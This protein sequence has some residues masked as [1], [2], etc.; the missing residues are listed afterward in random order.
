MHW[1]AD[2]GGEQGQHGVGDVQG[3]DAGEK[4]D[5]ERQQRFDG[6]ALNSPS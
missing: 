3:E 6:T 4:D 1:P 2:F 5:N